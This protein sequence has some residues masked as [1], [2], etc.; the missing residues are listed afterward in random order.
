MFQSTNQ[1]ALEFSDF[2]GRSRLT[3]QIDQ[4]PTPAFQLLDGFFPAATL[5]PAREPQE[6]LLGCAALIFSNLQVLQHQ[7]WLVYNN[8]QAMTL[9]MN[10][11]YWFPGFSHDC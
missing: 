9:N 5:P 10:D 7:F 6:R 11:L 8:L 3:E 1:V 4:P 2:S